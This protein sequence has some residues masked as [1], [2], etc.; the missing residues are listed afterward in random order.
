MDAKYSLPVPAQGYTGPMGAVPPATGIRSP[1]RR[2]AHLP[3]PGTLFDSLEACPTW[4]SPSSG[5]F[6]IS[7]PSSRTLAR[8]DRKVREGRLVPLDLRGFPQELR[9][10]GLSARVG[11]FIGSF[12]PFQMTHL[13]M[14][15]RFLASDASEADALFIV[16]KARSIPGSPSRPITASASRYSSASL[17]ASSSPFRAP[18]YRRG[19]GH[20]R[21]RQRLIGLH[22]GASLRLTHLLGSDVLPMAAALLP[23]DLEAWGEAAADTASTSTSPSTSRAATGEA[24][25]APSPRRYGASASGWSSTGRDRD[26]LEH[27]LPFRGSDHS[28]PS[29]RGRPLQ[30]RAPLSLR[31]VPVLVR[32]ELDIPRPRRPG[33]SG[34]PEYQ[35]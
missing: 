19:R 29:H 22:P 4:A 16:P 7:A 9:Y 24:A 11:I 31:H 18:G 10:P 6:T 35:I 32:R 34:G 23:D 30:A 25:C 2:E 28:R 12:D 27:G 33:S 26:A 13:A 1:R 20:H 3:T 14:A 8:I 17:P 5:T 21:D 15:L